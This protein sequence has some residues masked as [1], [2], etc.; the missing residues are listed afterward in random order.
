MIV[1]RTNVIQNGLVWFLSW[2]TLEDEISAF[3]EYGL[4]FLFLSYLMRDF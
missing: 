3:I 4:V 1:M 2:K